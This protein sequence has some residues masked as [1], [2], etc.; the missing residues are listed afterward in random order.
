MMIIIIINN[1]DDDEEEEENNDDND[2]DDDDGDGFKYKTLRVHS[3]AP[4]NPNQP[5]TTLSISSTLETGEGHSLR[6]FV[7]ASESARPS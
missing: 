3:L 4:L 5:A 1:N 7:S 6:R 2:D